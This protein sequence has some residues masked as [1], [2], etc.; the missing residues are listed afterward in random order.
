M[1]FYVNL[2]E[3]SDSDESDGEIYDDADD[4]AESNDDS[5]SDD[6]DEYFREVPTTSV[7]RRIALVAPGGSLKLTRRAVGMCKARPEA[8]SQAKPSPNRPSQAGPC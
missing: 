4:D 5:E 3:T 6:D 8:V 2:P 7:P 1:I